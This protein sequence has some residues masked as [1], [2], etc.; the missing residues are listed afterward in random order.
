MKTRPRQ[1]TAEF[2]ADA[3]AMLDQSGRSIPDVAE[4]LGISLQTAKPSRKLQLMKR[5][6]KPAATTSSV[7]PAPLT[8][9]LTTP[10]LA[11]AWGAR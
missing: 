8:T 7:A 5:K 1:N 6:E 11:P 9:L 2:C 3:L 4:A 10:A